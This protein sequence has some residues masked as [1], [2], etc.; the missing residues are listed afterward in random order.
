MK[1]VSPI[2]KDTYF[3]F[4]S[5]FFPGISNIIFLAIFTRMIG[6]GEYGEY[7]FYL[8]QFNLIASFCFGWLNQSELR[9]GSDLDVDKLNFHSIFFIFVSSLLIVPFIIFFN[10]NNKILVDNFLLSFYCIFLICL[11]SFIKNIFQRKLFSLD[12]AKLT[13]L[14]SFLCL[15]LP[16]FIIFFLKIDMN[17]KSLLLTTGSSYL[18]AI[19]VLSNKNFS[20][21]KYLFLK[22]KL[23]IKIIKKWFYFGIP[24]SI[25]G[26]MGLLLP[27]LDR[28][29]INKFFGNE[30]LGVY[31]SL[32]ELLIRI[33][34]FFIFPITMALYPRIIKFWNNNDKI[35]AI[36]IIKNSIRFIMILFIVVLLINIFFENTIFEL[37]KILVPMLPNESSELLL[38]LFLTGITWQLSFFSHKLIELNE[39]TYLMIIFIFISLLINLIGN[40]YYLPKYGIIATAFTSFLSAFT[41]FFM[42]LIYSLI[43]I[44]R[45]NRSS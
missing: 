30:S 13:T 45:I 14:Q 23:S 18:I 36:N 20:I 2:V 7:S 1:T 10:F 26:I 9:Y 11:F 27:Y 42:T 19:F 5:K 16:L 43:E 12:V 34:S 31:S 29:Y 33:F 40:N 6:I 4:L 21:N 3:Y 15:G 38:P 32:S 25:W 39:K 37:V 8:S 17:S 41:Y 28:Y 44:G 22:K 35:K 24:V